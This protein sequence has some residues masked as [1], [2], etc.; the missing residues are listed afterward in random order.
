MNFEKL[1]GNGAVEVI[2]VLEERTFFSACIVGPSLQ[3][4]AE[5]LESKI[6]KGCGQDWV[7]RGSEEVANVVWGFFYVVTSARE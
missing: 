4:G 7:R 5:M 3:N 1:A 6:G 2:E